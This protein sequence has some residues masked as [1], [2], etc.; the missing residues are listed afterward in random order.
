MATKV[1][2]HVANGY[3][4]P[5]WVKI[6]SKGS[7]IT[8]PPGGYGME[9]F[10]L[11]YCKCSVRVEPNHFVTIVSASRKTICKGKPINDCGIIVNKSGK[12]IVAAFQCIWTDGLGHGHEF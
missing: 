4:E 7:G 9:G 1:N 5:I 6:T 3:T 8:I 11:L 2:V 10:T 12:V